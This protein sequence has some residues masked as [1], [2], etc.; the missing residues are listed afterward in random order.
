MINNHYKRLKHLSRND[1][2]LEKFIKVYYDKSY[3]YSIRDMKNGK[4]VS[5]VYPKIQNER[6]LRV[7]ETYYKERLNKWLNYSLFIWL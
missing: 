5:L 3:E 2:E 6:A 1:N 7:L 4:S